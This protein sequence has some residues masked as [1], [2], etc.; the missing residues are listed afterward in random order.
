M[1][2][3]MLLHARRPYQNVHWPLEAPQEF[4][5]MF[6]EVPD[7]ARQHVCAMAKILDEG[8]GNITAALKSK[9]IYDET[10]QI[11]SSDN[12]GPTNHNE[13]TFSDNFPMRGGKNTIW[14]VRSPSFRNSLAYINILVLPVA[15][16]AMP[17]ALYCRA[18]PRC[19]VR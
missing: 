5:D 17:V 15:C 8:V 1:I 18:I 14:E 16:T 3:T 7:N 4:L 2:Y 9:G 12:G 13:G 19:A 10:I 11:F 6:S